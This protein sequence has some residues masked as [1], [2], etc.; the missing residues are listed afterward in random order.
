MGLYFC[1]TQACC[2]PCSKSYPYAHHEGV[3][4]KGGVVLFVLDLGSRWRI[5]VSLACWERALGTRRL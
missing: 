5:M 1:Y 4:G 3:W 2:L